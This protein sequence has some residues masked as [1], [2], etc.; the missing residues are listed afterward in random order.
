MRRKMYCINFFLILLLLMVCCDQIQCYG[1]SPSPG[2]DLLDSMP[3]GRYESLDQC[4]VINHHPNGDT[5]IYYKDGV[6]IPCYFW[7]SYS[8]TVIIVDQE[9]QECYIRGYIRVEG[10]T[11]YYDTGPENEIILHLVEPYVPPTT[12]QA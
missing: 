2:M 1:V 9:T 7:I 3:Y 5:A 11:L 4:L 12:S 10:T 8:G 6:E